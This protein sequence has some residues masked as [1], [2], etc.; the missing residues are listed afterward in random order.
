MPAEYNLAALNGVSFTKGCYVGQEFMVRPAGTAGR[1]RAADQIRGLAVVHGMSL[2]VTIH[3][4]LQ[5]S[6]GATSDCPTAVRTDCGS[7][8]MTARVLCCVLLLTLRPELCRHGCTSRAWCAKGSCLSGSTT[9]HQVGLESQWLPTVQPRSL[10]AMMC[11]A[12]GWQ[13]FARLCNI[14]T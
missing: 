3:Q 1:H 4:E 9:K 14:V 10:P 13:R 6:K 2:P 11:G 7:L 8:G 5:A 12:R